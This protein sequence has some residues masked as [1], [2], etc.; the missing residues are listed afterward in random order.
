MPITTHIDKTKDLVTHT[1]TGILTFDEVMLVVKTFYHGDPTKNVM[2]NLLK[3]EDITLTSEEI[4]RIATFKPRFQGKREPG[5]TV[6]VAQDD[7][8]YGLSRMFI[9]ENAISNAP[10]SVMVFRNIN[11]ARQWLDEP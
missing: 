1:A 3:A 11:E 7:L 6:I 9:M 4:E 2:W 8:D 5:K 10:H